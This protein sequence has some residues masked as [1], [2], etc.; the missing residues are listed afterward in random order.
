M[1][2]QYRPSG[3]AKLIIKQIQFFLWKNTSCLHAGAPVEQFFPFFKN[4]IL[5][6]LMIILTVK[7][8]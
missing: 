8:F 4:L 6:A 5:E 1:N 7:F 3:R 2:K